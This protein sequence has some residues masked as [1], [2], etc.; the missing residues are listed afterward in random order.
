MI[1]EV[2]G[3]PVVVM[4]GETP[5]W[6][7][8]SSGDV[9]ADVFQLETNLAA[10]GYDPD[11]TV[12]IDTEFTANTA[13]MVE[14]WQ[15]D[16]GVEITGSVDAGRV[17]IVAGPSSVVSTASIG[18]VASEL[19]SV[20]PE[21]SVTDVVASIDGVITGLGAVGETIEHGSVLYT[22]RRDPGRCHRG[23]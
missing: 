20:A 14:R 5:M 4:F 10:L 11:Q 18:S 16:I 19:A 2:D 13:L 3:E 8:L 21:R 15:E 12:D 23:G 9:G 6:R 17:A 22:R 7:G 1:A